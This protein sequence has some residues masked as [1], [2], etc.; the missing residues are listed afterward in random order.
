MATRKA[1]ETIET[2]PEAKEPE[3]EAVPQW[4][5]EP[6][7]ADIEDRLRVWGNMTLT[8]INVLRESAPNWSGMLEE[9]FVTIGQF[10]EASRI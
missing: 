8:T 7:T 1:R 3:A 2:E 5:L 10:I 9:I 4:E 6:I